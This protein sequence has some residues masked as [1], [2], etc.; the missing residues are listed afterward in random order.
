ST[1]PGPRPWQWSLE[2]IREGP[3]DSLA[4]AGSG[5]PVALNARV[6][7]PRQRLLEWFVN[8]G[9]GLQHGIDLPEAQ[10]SG[11]IVIDFGIDGSLTPKIGSDRQSIVFVSET[12][13][14]VLS[15]RAMRVF[16]A[17]GREVGARWQ[18]AD[19]AGASRSLRLVL[20]AADHVAPLHVRGL[21]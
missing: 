13:S 11:S 5:W 20:D 1:R 14:P 2:M 16:D 9:K 17:S 12:G 6:E 10:V 4:D 7:L 3:P 15:Y 21:I 18:H 8:S 19:A